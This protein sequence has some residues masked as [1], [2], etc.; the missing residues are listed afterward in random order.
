MA[1][2]AVQTITLMKSLSV[3][4]LT[5]YFAQ[6]NTGSSAPAKPTT[7]T[8][9]SPWGTN[10]PAINLQKDLYATIRTLFSDGTTFEYS[11]PQKYSS[12][13]A[14]KAAYNTATGAQSTASAALSKTPILSDTEPSNPTQDMLW[15]DTTSGVLK[16]YT[17]NGLD[18][19]VW[20]I[21]ND[22]STAIEDLPANIIAQLDL[23]QRDQDLKEWVSQEIV[24][25]TTNFIQTDHEF[26][27]Q[28][29]TYKKK[30]E[31]YEGALE[32]HVTNQLKYIRFDDGVIK[33]GDEQSPYSLQLY[34]DKIAMIWNGKIISIWD[35][36][37]FQVS[38]LKIKLASWTY[39]F[40][41]QANPDGSVSIRKE[42]D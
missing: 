29:P 10:E 4:S 2:K 28:F 42:A 36:D 38:K 23:S 9:S 32:E 8:P 21:V 7:L 18:E 14:A 41:F 20:E 13:E 17:I 15:I 34:N 30:I 3:D 12:Y 5:I 27:M 11:D 1:V 39:G 22:F 31:G 19:G 40:V 26:I 35:T 16:R 25:Q 6:V 33:L 24:K 37:T